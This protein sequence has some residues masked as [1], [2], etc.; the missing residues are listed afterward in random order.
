MLQARAGA[1]AEIA[2]L[3]R[4]RLASENQETISRRVKRQI[5]Q[6]IDP[7]LPNQIGSLRIRQPGVAV[8]VIRVTAD[9][10]RKRI[11]LDHVRIAEDLHLPMIVLPKQRQ[12]IL[13]DDV[14]AEIRRHITDPQAAIGIAS[15]SVRLNELLE[16]FGMLPVPLPQFRQNHPGVAAGIVKVGANQIAVRFAKSGSSRIACR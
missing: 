2:H 5:D 6:N 1:I 7:I 13:A 8:P 16:W 12:Q 14:L 4:C 9:L 3:H 15:R 10:F 11:T